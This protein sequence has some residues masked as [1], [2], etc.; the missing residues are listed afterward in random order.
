VSSPDAEDDTASPDP[1][2]QRVASEEY[3]AVVSV[4][5]SNLFGYSC[6]I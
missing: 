6:F 5:L 4:T 3:D 1:D 2:R